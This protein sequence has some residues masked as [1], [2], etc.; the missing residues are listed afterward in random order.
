MA[1][2]KKTSTIAMALGTLMLTATVAM[3]AP[4]PWKHKHWHHKHH[5]P[6]WS[7]IVGNIL[8]GVSSHRPRRH[9]VPA[10]YVT[11]YR[12]VLVAPGHYEMRTQK[13]LVEPGHLEMK[14]V[15]PVTKTILKAD[16]TTEVVV[17]QP[18]QTTQVWVPDRYEFKTTKVWV[19][20]QYQTRVFQRLVPGHYA[21]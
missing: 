16:G 10:H 5:K 9:Y 11:E 4:P 7:S 19:P 13:V 8:G 17:V 15:P 6:H 1:R 18:A 2:T 3:A 21:Y 14:T 20:A 12:Q